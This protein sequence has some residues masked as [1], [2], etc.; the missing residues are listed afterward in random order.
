MAQTNPPIGSSP[1]ANMG[2]QPNMANL[3]NQLQGQ[4]WRG[5]V[6]GQTPQQGLGGALG[7]MGSPGSSTGVAQSPNNAQLAN[8]LAAQMG[9][10][11]RQNPFAGQLGAQMGAG[12]GQPANM[13][14]MAG[15]LRAQMRPG[16]LNTMQPMPP[17][18]A[19]GRGPGQGKGAGNPAQMQAMKQQI[20]RLPGAPR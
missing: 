10:Q 4:V 13:A 2:Q 18:G 3:A 12:V 8:Q 16:R 11:Q 1:L 7:S 5:P 6:P 19:P 15:Q 20:A 9:G 14:N 17:M